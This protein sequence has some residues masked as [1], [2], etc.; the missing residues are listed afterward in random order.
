[1]PFARLSN[2]YL[3]KAKVNA[4]ATVLMQGAEGSRRAALE[5]SRKRNGRRAQAEQDAFGTGVGAQAHTLGAV[6]TPGLAAMLAP[7]AAAAAAATGV[8]RV[9][10]EAEAVRPTLGMPSAAAC[11]EWIVRAMGKGGDAV[12]SPYPVHAIMAE[13]VMD[14]L[15]AIR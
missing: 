4:L 14:S 12:I 8:K 11:G 2:Y 3:E 6:V 10:W 13:G 15:L 7:A 5:G 1:M 9:G